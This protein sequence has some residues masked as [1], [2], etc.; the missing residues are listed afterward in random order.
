MKAHRGR[1]VLLMALMF[2]APTIGR[3]QSQPYYQPHFPPEEFRARW[4]KIFDK[5]GPG[6]I[7]I[8]QGAPQV[9]GF[10]YPRQT[11]EFYYLCGIETPHSYI[12]LDGRT[13]RAILFLPPRNPR[14]ES[15]EGRV[16]SAEDA[17]LAKRLT[18]VD[19]TLSTQM[20]TVDWLRQFLGRP[21]PVIYTPFA[22][23]EGAAQ[24][25]GELLAA[26]ASIALDYWDGRPSREAHFVGLLRTRLPQ[27]EVRDLS[28][29]LDELRSVKSPREIALIR[30]A[31]Q[32]AGLGI[33][34]A[35]KATRPGIYEYQLDAVAR[36]VYL[37][38][39]ARL[40][41]YR[42]IV[43]SGTAN[44]WNIHY[45]RN[46]DRLKDGDLVL[47]DYAPDYGYYTSDIARMWP[48]NGKFS[49]WQR[50]LLQFV[51]EY[52]KAILARIRPGVTVQT[53]MDEAK[54]AM[55]EVFR[56][57]K[58]SKPIYEQ[59]AR[60]LVETGGGV[61]SHPV[62]MAVHDVG[63]YTRDVLKPGQ[64]F[65]I[66]PQLRVPEEN[67]YL[68]YEDVV[69]VTETGVENFTDFLPSELDDIEKLV[70]RGGLLQMF[71]PASEDELKRLGKPQASDVASTA[72]RAER[73]GR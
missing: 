41:G 60:R 65:S 4:N 45:Y 50:E 62:G 66:D 55:E 9:G 26:N 73:N 68:R 5:I 56:R 22:P 72:D 1:V 71:P 17:E 28:P 67:L 42:S 36:Y 6:A 7:A 20:L 51:L 8:V 64:V 43:A 23:A 69:V 11:N 52:R 13:R 18:G 44:I 34:E 54:A 25:R 31:S 37:V 53:I 63:A 48:V 16:L 2:L 14:L 47:M 32:L 12:I 38:N 61:F 57:T 24:S 21:T 29:I 19:E 58:F 33:I 46:L 70:G 15:A 39:G 27:I 10:I 40:E 30:R 49:P 3:G 35:M 59:A